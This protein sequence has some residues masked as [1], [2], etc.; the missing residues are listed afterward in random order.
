MPSIAHTFANEQAMADHAKALWQQVVA[1]HGLI[2]LSGPL[3]AGKSTWVR[4]L[5]RASGVEGHI[6][7]PTYT[8]LE[9]YSNGNQAF[10]HCD[11]YRL[12]SGEACFDLG[13]DAYLQDHIICIEWPEQVAP[14]LPRPDLWCHLDITDKG[15]SMRI[16]QLGPMVRALV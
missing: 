9:P 4:A 8:L 11:F 15:H 12:E 16:E 7:S 3:G 1:Q 2:F 5:L 13:I 14:Y 6:V 10:L